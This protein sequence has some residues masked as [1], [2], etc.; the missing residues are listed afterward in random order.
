MAMSLDN[1]SS[2]YSHRTEP[3]IGPSMMQCNITGAAG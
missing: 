2:A 3:D 1:T